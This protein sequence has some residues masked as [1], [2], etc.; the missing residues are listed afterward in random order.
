[1][2]IAPVRAGIYA[3]ISSDREG[4]TLGVRRQLADCERLGERRGWE[5]VE[6][7]VDDDVSA[8]S[9]KARPEYA[10][11]LDDL[12]SGVIDGLLVYD[13]DRLHR[14]PRELE[15]FID[16]CDRLHLTNVASVSGQID[17]T[18]TD[19]RFQARILGAMAAKSSDDTSRRIQRKHEE[20]AE[21]GKLSGGGSRPYGY[22]ADR[23]TVNPA[24]AEVVRECARRFLAGES[25]R[26]ICSD[27]NDRGIVAAS[28]GEWSPQTLRRM[29]YSGRIAGQR[30]HKGEIVAPAEWD[31]IITTAASATIR[32]TLDDP[33]RRTNRSAR[34]YLLTRVLR[35]G[36]CGEPM[37]ARP[38]S[39]GQ[40]RYACAK[41]PG[42][43]GCGHI[44]LG[45]DE[46]E[47][48]VAEA[49]LY[50]LD[51]PEFA[52]ILN[53][54]QRSQPDAERYQREADEAQA[55]LA[56]LADAYGNKA[57]GMAE[58]LAARKPIEARLTL[59]RKQLAKATRTT[60]LD[61][62]VGADSGLR[63][64]WQTLD[65]TRQ[66]A[67]IKAV[68]DHVVVAPGRQGYNRFDASRLQP[69]WR[70]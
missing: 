63:E 2:I 9:G 47:A 35:C 42:L 20:L 14:Q 36:L 59:A 67:I 64:R 58:W 41:G 30:E 57:I 31:A 26:A 21:N 65:L 34:R 46:A 22:N 28:G 52:A 40:K 53:G 23:L 49:V 18:T 56:E 61:G 25:I 37:V 29:L 13:L 32:A 1:M 62:N 4:D 15:A 33:A 55:Q 51:S 48:F 12:A 16:L 3:R 27:L 7:Y 68:L 24:E 70:V 39:G 5:V 54:Q 69:V 50:R 6:R 10:R 43:S 38:R 19:G 8:W 45:A 60:V 11:C 66:Q 44:Y 17:L